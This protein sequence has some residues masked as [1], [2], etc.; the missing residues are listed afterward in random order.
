MLVNGGRAIVKFIHGLYQMTYL[1]NWRSGARRII[2][3]CQAQGVEVPTWCSEGG[4]VTITFKRPKFD[5]SP[6]TTPPQVEFLIQKMGGSYMTMREMAD[7]CNIKDLKYFR[8]SYITPAS[9]RG[10]I[11]RLYP[12]HP[13]HPKQQYQLTECAKEW[14]KKNS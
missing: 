13:K 6:S 11:E 5:T 8:G 9:E 10:M 14:M 4:F 12:D 7:V 2:D 1:E 3:A